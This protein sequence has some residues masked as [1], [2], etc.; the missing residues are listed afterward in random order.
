MRWWMYFWSGLTA[1]NAIIRKPYMLSTPVCAGIL[2]LIA[3]ISI[4]LISIT[5]KKQED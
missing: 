2:C 4:L 5:Y 3:V 1:E